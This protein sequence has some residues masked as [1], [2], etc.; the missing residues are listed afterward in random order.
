MFCCAICGALIDRGYLE[1]DCPNG[2]YDDLH[3]KEENLP[4]VSE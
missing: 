2:C 3:P 1:T 4:G